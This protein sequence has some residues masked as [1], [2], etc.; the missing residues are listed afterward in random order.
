MEQIS[1]LPP[2]DF[3]EQKCST[4]GVSRTNRVIG[5]QAD[6]ATVPVFLY[7][8]YLPLREVGYLQS[9]KHRRQKIMNKTKEL[10]LKRR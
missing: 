2:D 1:F 9:K 5:T 7:I 10:E 8:T 4:P 6:I 3:P